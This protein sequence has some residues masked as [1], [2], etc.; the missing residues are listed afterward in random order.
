MNELDK[1][2][3]KLTEYLQHLD[4]LII[5]FSG[6]VDSALLLKVA[7]DTIADRVL[8]ITADS[9]SIPR[10]E[11]AEAKTIAKNIGAKHLVIQTN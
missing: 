8:A 3:A 5:A 1:K 11:L 9:P 10:K 7:Y 6:G 4:K 2:Y